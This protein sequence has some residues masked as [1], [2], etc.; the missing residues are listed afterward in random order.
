MLRIVFFTLSF[1]LLAGCDGLSQWAYN[2]GLSAE[3]SRAGLVD[4]QIDTTD[5][6]HWAYLDSETTNDLP[7][8]MLVHGFGADSSNWVRMV[9]ELEGEYRFIVPDLPGHGD[10]TRDLSLDYSI[11]PQAQ[12]L[13]TLADA[14]DVDQFHIAGSSMGGAISISVSLQA[15]QRVL[16]LG[17]LN[18]A[19]VTLV[20]PEFAAL[21]EQGNNPLIP[22]TPDDMFTTMDWAMADAP[23][24][25]DFFVTEMGKLKAANYDVAVKVHDDINGEMQYA[26]RLGEIRAPTLIVWG[27]L[28]RLLGLDNAEVF[29]QQIRNSRAVIL[30]DI[31]H[32]PM[33]EAPA[34]TA[35]ALRRFWQEAHT[36]AQHTAQQL[37]QMATSE[38]LATDQGTN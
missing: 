10:S 9:N 33:A 2:A 19:G 20:T 12:R 5:G 7:A 35:D 15:P 37:E 25:P 8:V 14:L 21:I 16:S 32:L 29:D 11:E 3:K 30:K 4:K 6:I 17:L 22:Q 13:L 38:A 23:W 18:A 24:M 28:D 31:G 36:Q 27:E 34:K 1:M 26:E